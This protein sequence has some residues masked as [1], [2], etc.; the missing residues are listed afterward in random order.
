MSDSKHALVIG[1][2]GVSGWGVLT[3]LL[4]YPSPTTWSRITG[5]TNRP[6]SLSEAQIS[7]TD[8]QS[9]RIKLV[10]GMDFFKSVEEV[11]TLLNSRIPG[12]ESVT[13]V[14][15]TA[16]IHHAFGEFDSVWKSNVGM[17][18]T[19]IKALEIAA[20]L[21]QFFVLQTGGKHYG[22]DFGSEAVPTLLNTP[23]GEER[24]RLDPPFDD[25]IFYYGQVDAMIAAAKG[26]S[27]TWA[28]MRPDLIVGFVPGAK[29]SVSQQ[30]AARSVA[31]YLALY[32]K[33]H[34]KGTDC[35]FLGSQ[36]NWTARKTDSS[37]DTIARVSIFAALMPGSCGAG[38]AFN[39]VD[40]GSSWEEEWP[41]VC[42]EFGLNGTGP[43]PKAMG[44]DELGE[45][46][47]LYKTES[48]ELAQEHQ[49]IGNPW[50]G[51]TSFFLWAITVALDYDREYDMRKI[52]GLGFRDQVASA[53]GWK[54]AIERL[55]NAK[56]IP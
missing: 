11:I 15:F 6:L 41:I 53:E 25:K 47:E 5:T 31:L 50:E 45:W 33:I 26:K 54:I 55:R 3:Q 2:S 37:Q 28:E 36:I 38:N 8:Q 32:R 46:F 34:G 7:P 30:D 48:E 17:V 4:I 40:L 52:T 21:M 56:I 20:P 23:Y 27:W 10:S 13:H 9:G 22:M 39:T 44:M 43:G 42:A 35:P 18:N 1:A 12:I 16:Y 51:F 19:T 24:P 49:L 29:G 14:F